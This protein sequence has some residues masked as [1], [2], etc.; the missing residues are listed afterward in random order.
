[1]MSIINHSPFYPQTALAFIE[2]RQYLAIAIGSFLTD[3][4]V[5]NLSRHSVKFYTD[6]LARNLIVWS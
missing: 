2:G 6:Y 1:M 5:R 3:C 4:Q